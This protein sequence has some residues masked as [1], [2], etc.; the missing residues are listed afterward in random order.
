MPNI[1]N[2]LYFYF[3]NFTLFNVE[4]LPF[5]FKVPP[6]HPQFNTADERFGDVILS[7]SCSG[8]VGR[9]LNFTHRSTPF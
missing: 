6:Q 3:T 8:C 2:Y 1:R 4:Q 7:S 9:P 5:R